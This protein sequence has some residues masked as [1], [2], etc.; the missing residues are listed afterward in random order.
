[1]KFIFIIFIFFLSNCSKPKSV[2]ICGDH[3]C[4]NKKEAEQFFEEN[5]TLEVKIVDKNEKK[6]IN[7]IELNLNENSS[8]ERK[9]TL[10]TKENTS[11]ELKV[12]SKKEK[13][14]IK[15]NINNKKKEK[16][17]IKKKDNNKYRKDKSKKKVKKE[18][19]KNNMNKKGTTVTDVCTILDKCS[20][21]EISK[22]LLEQG[23]NKNFPDITTRQ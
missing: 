15:R 11:K 3:I 10:L 19:I 12:L 4:I 2:L 14:K 16:K 9:V 7:L 23:R 18:K 20:I 21:D 6:E 5:L 13:T 17:V 1:M 22:F 8:G